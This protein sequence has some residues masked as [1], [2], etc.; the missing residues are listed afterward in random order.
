MLYLV[1]FLLLMSVR[2]QLVPLMNGKTRMKRTL[3]RS[4]IILLLLLS[5]VLSVFAAEPRLVKVGAFNYYPAIFQ[6]SDG[7]I[8]GFY[9]DALADLA[10]RENLRIEYVYGSWNEGLERIRTGEVDLLTSVAYTPERASYMDYTKNRLITVWGELYVLPESPIDGIREVAGKKIAVMKGDY[11]GQNFIDLARKFDI[12]CQFVELADFEE[13]FQAIAAK[14]VDGGI[15]N[16]TFGL[17]KHRQY[18][19]RSTGVVFNPFDIYLTVAKGKNQEL[20]ALMDRYLHDWR[21]QQDSVYGQARRAWSHGSSDTLRVLPAWLKH[22][23]AVFSLLFVAATAFIVLLRQQVRKKTDQVQQREA[24]LREQSEMIRLLLDSAAEAIY[25]LDRDGTC[26]LCN[27]ACLQMLGYEQP[28]Q[29]L[30]KNMHKLI[31]HTKADGKPFPAEECR[32]FKACT[33]GEKTHCDN[34]LYWRS[35]GSSFP[36]EYWSYP[37]IQDGQVVGAVV[38]FLD[39]TERRQFETALRES[40]ERHRSI[41]ENS[42]SVMLII[43]PATQAF[44]DANHAATAFYGWTREQLQTM[45]ISDI[46]TLSPEQIAESMR[47]AQ[48]RNLHHFHFKHRLANGTIRDVEVFSSPILTSGRQLLFSI[49]HDITERKLVEETLTFLMRSGDLHQNGSFFQLL[50]QYLAE[51]LGMDYV[52]IDRL[53]SDGL[54]AQTVAVYNNGVFEDNVRYTLL[55]TPCGEVVGK[56]IC[57]FEQ[58]VRHRF[59]HDQVLQDLQAE[60]YVG[61]TLW[62]SDGQP[63]GLIAAIGRQPLTDQCPAE[64]M[65][66][67]VAL[68]AAAELE[69]KNAEDQLLESESRYKNLLEHAPVAVMINQGGRIVLVNRAC[70]K[71]FG[72]TSKEQLLGKTPYELFHSSCPEAVRARIATMLSQQT[73]VPVLEETIVRLDGTP[74]EVE[75]TAAP[76]PSKGETGIHVVLSD[77][78]ERKKAELAHQQ[79][80]EQL[81][82]SQRMEA[83]GT[84][85]GGIAHDFNNILTAIIGY[86]HISQMGLPPDAPQRAPIQ[87]ITEAANR[88]THLTRDLLLF[89]RK[90]T[91]VR[92]VID[93]HECIIGTKGFLKRIISENIV[94]ET[95]FCAETIKL[96]ADPQ[97]L[98]QVLL[99]LAANARD[100]MPDGGRITLSSELVRLD[101]NAATLLGLANAG[102]Y[103][104]I[105]FADTGKGIDPEDLTRVFD[106]FFT[107]KEIGKGTG[108]GLPIVYGIVTGHGGVI[109]IASTPGQGTVLTIY[110][111]CAQ[112]APPAVKPQDTGQ[113]LPRG[114]ET[115]LMAEDSERIRDMIS[116]V[117]AEFGY[118]VITAVDGED[119][120]RLFK[121]HADQISLL[122]FDL[123]M[124]HLGGHEAYQQIIQIRP[125][126]PVLFTT[127]YAPQVAEGKLTQEQIEQLLHKP[128]AIVKLLK[129][130]RS[131]LDA[132]EKPE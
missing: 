44:V 61:T 43:D 122:L 69:R 20:L 31:H 81:R 4:I 13:V 67:L 10:Q 99:N 70:L 68:R 26:T 123:V 47:L 1:W 132:Q 93:L 71:L 117:L 85:A 19:L 39:I 23:I 90:Q 87:Q 33:L 40:E 37:I 59:P 102:E 5:G 14:K 106:P 78:S 126:I 41:F 116:Q 3:W 54:E 113:P 2:T 9:V 22:A 115:I 118:Q 57:R 129:A 50:A 46:N 82:H 38:T 60:S 53:E 84:L 7:Q 35:D 110:L 73:A 29:L 120:V 51:A 25:R 42:L 108:L 52:C 76:F 103:A 75:V 127:G 105:R 18:G 79:I 74:V 109:K 72:A 89:S 97:Q 21:Q 17:P 95:S 88:A 58:G 30:G 28:E 6:D 65:L 77:I 34:E 121:Q 104:V 131:A 32:I 55:D 98:D 111:P 62:G 11:N 86:A 64:S 24:G 94:L 112:D 27:A 124:P 63:I 83:I 15:V 16:S 48:Q 12:S 49:I 100:A 92:R 114:T 8:K 80:E 125:D 128:Y 56:T 130:V 66:Q 119:A 96:Y 36:V 45:R 107:T 91:T 101:T